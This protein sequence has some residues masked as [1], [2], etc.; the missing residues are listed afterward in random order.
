MDTALF[1]ALAT[2]ASHDTEAHVVHCLAATRVHTKVSSPAPA[3]P[4]RQW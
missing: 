4:P 3:F 2:K 1:H